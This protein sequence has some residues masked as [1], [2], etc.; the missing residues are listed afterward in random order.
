MSIVL[1]LLFLVLIVGVASL[2]GALSI[3]GQARS[4]AATATAAAQSVAARVALP[5]SPDRPRRV[6]A[7]VVGRV[8]VA[9]SRPL[10]FEL[11]RWQPRRAP[12][13]TC[14]P[15]LVDVGAELEPVD[16]GGHQAVAEIA[17]H[18]SVAT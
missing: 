18:L 4:A 17:N 13:G 8:E 12:R 5:L 16:A 3:L 10:R 7:P 11:D 6:P 2:V 15:P 1:A 14:P 9:P